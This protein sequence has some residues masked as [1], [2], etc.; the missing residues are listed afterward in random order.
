M[1]IQGDAIRIPLPSNSVHLIVTSPPYL[2][3]REYSR[4]DNYEEYLLDSEKW[5]KECYRILCDGGRIAINIPQGYGRPGI[6]TE[7]LTIGADTTNLIR[8]VGFILRGH[9]IWNKTHHVLGTAWGSWLS[10]S[11]PY[12][13][14]QHEII[15]VAHKGNAKR[16]G[17]KSTINSIDFIKSTSSVWYISPGIAN[18]WHPAPFPD[19]IPRRLIEL[20][21]FV[22]DIICDP[23][24]GS[25]TTERMA[26]SL[27]R[28]GIGIDLNYDYCRRAKDSLPQLRMPLEI[29]DAS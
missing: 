13:Q 11:N 12:L 17:G 23:F 15:I 1:L 29:E 26:I 7:Y 19:E 4:W 10:A 14:D 25:G 18:R 22:G 2:N 21:S 8:N 20:Y 6:G 24:S 28:K 16:E 5:W 3:A 9:I 27:G